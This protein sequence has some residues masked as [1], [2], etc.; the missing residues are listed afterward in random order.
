M[1]KPER[2]KKTVPQVII[3]TTLQE[4]ADA[5]SKLGA[6]QRETQRLQAMMNDEIAKIK[7]KYA[8][9]AD[10]YNQMIVSLLEGLHL[11]AES[12]R[13][14]LL[15]GGKKTVQLTTGEIGWRTTTPRVQLKNIEMIIERIKAKNLTEKFIRI[16][17][18]INKEAMLQEPEV[19]CQI[20]GVSIKQNETFWV[21]PDDTKLV[22]EKVVE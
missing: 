14:E 16:K 3:P 19:A 4:A 6:H 13:H 12:H 7:E 15:T 18:E 22:L 5:L 10:Q 2:V 20:P 21:K 1:A 8:E 9:Q 17:E 11:Y